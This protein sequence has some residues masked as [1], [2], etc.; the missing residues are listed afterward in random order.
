MEPLPGVEEVPW[1]FA[2]LFSS[3][4][5]LNTVFDLFVETERELISERTRMGLTRHGGKKDQAN[6]QDVRI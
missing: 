3:L 4:V 1:P 6:H 2:T 5:S